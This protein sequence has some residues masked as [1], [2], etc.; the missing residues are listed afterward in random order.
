MKN[1]PFTYPYGSLP[2]S[3]IGRWEPLYKNYNINLNKF[4]KIICIN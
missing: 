2:W 3:L 1:D 4:Y